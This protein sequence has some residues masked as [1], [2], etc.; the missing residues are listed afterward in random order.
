MRDSKQDQT[1][2]VREKQQ[3]QQEEEEEERQREEKARVDSLWESFKLESAAVL[4]RPST[5]REGGPGP[6]R[7]EGDKPPSPG[8]SKARCTPHTQTLLVSCFTQHTSNP[9]VV[10]G[11]TLLIHRQFEMCLIVCEYEGGV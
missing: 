5:E 8:S 10:N 7:G 3:Q 6:E 11:T 9:I 4:R 2:E 1:S